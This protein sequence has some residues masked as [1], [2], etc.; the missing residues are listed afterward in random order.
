MIVRKER[1][2]YYKKNERKIETGVS[3]T[4]DNSIYVKWEDVTD[5]ASVAADDGGSGGD[6]KKNY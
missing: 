2:K 5:T 1:K 4:N 3:R 6:S